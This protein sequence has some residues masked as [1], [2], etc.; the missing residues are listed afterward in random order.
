[1][2]DIKLKFCID[3]SDGC[4]LENRQVGEAGA[5]VKKAMVGVREKR[6]DMK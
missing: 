4:L 3:G 6:L 5:R 1:M 2:N